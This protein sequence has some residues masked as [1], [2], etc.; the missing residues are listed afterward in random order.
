MREK[1]WLKVTFVQR[2]SIAI[3]NDLR[4]MANRKQG[5]RYLIKVFFFG[6]GSLACH[7][8]TVTN[9]KDTIGEILTLLKS[10]QNEYFI[11]GQGRRPFV[12]LSYAQ[13]LDGKIAMIDHRQDI[14]LELEGSDT[15][16]PPF[17]GKSSSNYP[18][19]CPFSLRMTHALR[20][21]HEA[22]LIGG[23]T[24]EIDNP[25]L[26]NRLW[27]NHFQRQPR[28]VVLD[29]Q[30]RHIREME[31]SCRLRNPIICC[32]IQALRAVKH[33]RSEY[34]FLPCRCSDDG[35]LDLEDVLHKLTS[36]YGIQTLMVEGGA[37]T[38]SSFYRRGDLYDFLCITIA[39]KLLGSLAIGPLLMGPPLELHTCRFFNLGDD[40]VFVGSRNK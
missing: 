37:A 1:F 9:V 14:P 19:S 21:Q 10:G 38:L 40:A 2:N 34:D 39:P 30:L 32:S 18:L 25:R 23:N 29:T 27:G 8:Q 35:K 33:L 28:P 15:S 24:L 31:G 13:S 20:E 12:T 16:L 4:H 3:H 11:G 22:I 7:P 6:H 5:L 36:K 17:A 26:S